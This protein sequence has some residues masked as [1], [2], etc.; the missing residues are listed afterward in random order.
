MVIYWRTCLRRHCLQ[1]NHRAMEI[2]KAGRQHVCQHSFGST[3]PWRTTVSLFWTAPI[4]G[5]ISVFC[6]TASRKHWKAN[7]S[8][9]FQPSPAAASPPLSFC[10]VNTSH[11]CL[12]TTPQH[13]CAAIPACLPLSHCCPSP[14][15]HFSF[16]IGRAEYTLA[17][18][19]EGI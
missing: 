18:S 19:K 12:S 6:A 1:S 11:L 3:L 14:H 4:Y 10:A 5:D 15:R 2:D 7:S 9:F 13:P 17:H 16:T 8:Q